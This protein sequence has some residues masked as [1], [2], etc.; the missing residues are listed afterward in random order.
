MSVNAFFD[1]RPSFVERLER[2]TD[3]IAAEAGAALAGG[4]FRPW[5][6]TALYDFGWEVFGL[7]YLGREL[8]ENTRR[9]PATLAALQGV[10][11]VT[12]AVFTH[13]APSAHVRPHVGYTNK[14]LRCHL[15]LVVPPKCRIRVGTNLRVLERG[16]CLIFDDTVEHEAWNES[17]QERLVLI[18]DL[19]R[20]ALLDALSGVEPTGRTQLHERAVD[21]DQTGR[22]G[23]STA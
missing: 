13:L 2:C 14:V 19:V 10:P 18:V 9:C 5:P 21:R 6:E 1:A 17:S 20:Q 8:K 7:I 3:E 11:G 12:N 22:A 4:L 16:H 23:K 15:G